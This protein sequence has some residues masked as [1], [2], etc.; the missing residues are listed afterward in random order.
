MKDAPNIEMLEMYLSESGYV[1]VENRIKIL[2]YLYVVIQH[3][4]ITVLSFNTDFIITILYFFW[5]ENSAK[6]VEAATHH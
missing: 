5:N 2:N 4:F 6:T 3:R 1:Q